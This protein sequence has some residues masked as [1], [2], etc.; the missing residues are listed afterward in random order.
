M[1]N[2][3][4]DLEGDLLSGNGV[5]TLLQVLFLSLLCL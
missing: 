2:K 3:K 1:K 4:N 5:K